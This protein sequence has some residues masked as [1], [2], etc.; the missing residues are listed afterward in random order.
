TDD[1]PAG[2][3]E[4]EALSLFNEDVLLELGGRWS[5]PPP[6]DA[7]EVAALADGELGERARK[8]LDEAFAG[9][10]FV[11]KDPRL[12][13]LLPF[14]RRIIDEPLAV[15]STFRNPLE[16]ARSINRRDDLLPAYALSLWE[17]Y[18]RLALIDAHDL[19]GYL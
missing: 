12:C 16:V 17:R 18:Q 6:A 5:G 11:W 8:L 3:W 13:L 14:W 7:A 10:P 2:H 9:R 4:V 19:P 15:V 1:N